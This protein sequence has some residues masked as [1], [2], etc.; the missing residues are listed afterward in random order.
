MLGHFRL[1]LGGVWVVLVASVKLGSSADTKSKLVKE[2]LGKQV[3]LEGVFADRDGRVI[4][5][6]ANSEEAAKCRAAL[7]GFGLRDPEVVKP[8]VVVYDVPR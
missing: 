7:P 3:Q 2:V 1:L 8:K 5:R 4:I 6:A